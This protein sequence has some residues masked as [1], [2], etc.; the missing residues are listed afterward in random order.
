MHLVLVL[1]L[2][3]IKFE[4]GYGDIA[5]VTQGGIWFV[6]F[7]LPLNVTFVSVYMGTLAR[8]C[9]LL[10]TAYTQRI[11]R[12]EVA[13]K[14]EFISGSLLALEEGLH[15]D[16]KSNNDSGRKKPNIQSMQDVVQL[17]LEN[18]AFQDGELGTP[19][20]RSQLQVLSPWE[21][22][23]AFFSNKARQ[24]SFALLVLV[25]ERLITILAHEI[26]VFDTNAV[27]KDT[28]FVFTINKFKDTAEKW[29]V[30]DGA[31]DAFS[32]IVFESLIYVGEKRCAIE[33]LQAFLRLT[34][35]ECHKLFSP[36][37]GALEDA[38]TMEAWL[39]LTE[40]LA[41]S[42]RSIATFSMQVSN[43]KK[44]ELSGSDDTKLS[45]SASKDN[46]STLLAQ[47]NTQRDTDMLGKLR[48]IY[49]RTLEER[50]TMY[51][52]KY[53][54][55]RTIALWAAL[56]F[57]LYEVFATVYVMNIAHLPINK[58]MLFTM[59]T[60]TSAGFGSVAV[61]LTKGHLVFL[62][63]NIYISV[64]GVA[65]LVRTLCIPDGPCK[66]AGFL[67]T[68]YPDCPSF[69]LFRVVCPC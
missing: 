14:V 32:Q 9:M 47:C 20:L 5:P 53:L 57:F 6:I 50:Q 18:L 3:F 63:F 39:A 41:A 43:K 54:A 16:M 17:V 26:N 56:L 67:L 25:Q 2:F 10:S 61:P 13:E 65:V 1:I 42:L 40:E 19:S 52:S 38:G 46:D 58:A 44:A 30:P 36:F 28:T 51:L 8:Y 15:N 37:L 69:Y 21:K 68:V 22:S 45:P 31:R 7:W 59:Y 60:I 55:N 35:L 24:P 12:K 48:R 29:N 34:P 11:Y 66:T 62:I 49:N 4:V 33:N 64:T 23:G 27:V